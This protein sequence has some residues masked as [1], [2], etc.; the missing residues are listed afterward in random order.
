MSR[1]RNMFRS[2]ALA[3]A[4][5]TVAAPLA[6]ASPRYFGSVAGSWSGSGQIVAGT[7]KGTR[8]NCRLKGTQPAR[9]TMDIRGTCRV[10]L[11]S[12]KISATVRKRGR[13]YRGS[14]L[15]GARGKGMDIT[16]GRLHRN[17]LT[18]S[19]NRKQLNGAMVANLTG[20]NDLRISIS[21]W[22]GNDYVPV[23]GLQLK[24][25]RRG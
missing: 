25:D 18:V 11:F 19:I 17:K 1:F 15:D 2:G 6:D 16:A 13:S 21:V 23:I 12:Q 5:A 10:G 22:A 20:R 8:F 14:F 3:L 7:Y 24:R 4:F 9:Q